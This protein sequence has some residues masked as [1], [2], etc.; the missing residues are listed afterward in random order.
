[1]LAF[2]VLTRIPYVLTHDVQEDAYISA[3]AVHNLVTH[4]ALEFNVGDHYSPV[5]SLAWGYLA[6]IPAVLLPAGGLMFG[7]QA[8]GIAS[9]ALAILLLSRFLPSRWTVFALALCAPGLFASFLGMETGPCI[10]YLAFSLVALQDVEHRRRWL[11]VAAAAGPLIRPE[12]ILVSGLL[13][14]L[15]LLTA[16]LP[17][18][19]KLFLCTAPV[20]GAVAY[21]TMNLVLSGERISPTVVAKTLAYPHDHSLS[22]FAQHLATLASGQFILPAPKGV[23]AWVHLSVNI[24][25]LA[26][27]TWR[28]IIARAIAWRENARFISFVLLIAYGLPTAFA[29]GGQ[30]AQWY[31]FP[32]GFFAVFLGL[33]S[34]PPAWRTRTAVR[35]V[36]L[37]VFTGVAAGLLALAYSAG[38]QEYG[39]RADVGRWLRRQASPTATLLLEPAGYIPFYAGLKTYDDVGLVSPVVLDYLRIY[40]RRWWWPFVEDHWPDWIVDRHDFRVT[41]QNDACELSATEHRVL[42]ARYELVKVFHYDP[43]DY[44]PNGLG[45]RVL[46]LGSHA[47]YYVYRLKQSGDTPAA[48]SAVA[49][50]SLSAAATSQPQAQGAER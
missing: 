13:V 50:R 45:L 2:V 31:L 27:L 43:R 49:D 20:L 18:R 23:P 47:D 21:V 22:A 3:R 30:F 28:L 34:L 24:A 6:A 16:R 25:P 12:Y 37:T 35:A 26:L 36:M 5:T 40:G 10:L 42:L 7:F 14:S 8:L 15:T 29:L 4:G 32:C 38:T 39:Y 19:D 44:A 9:V 11:Y 1:M 46:R 17:T 41:A 48:S 33:W